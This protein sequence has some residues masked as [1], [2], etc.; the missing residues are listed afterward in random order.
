MTYGGGEDGEGNIFSIPMTGG[1]PTDLLDFNGTNGENPYGNL[2]LSGSTLY[3]MTYG[4]GY[5]GD[6]TLF[7]MNALGVGPLGTTGQTFTL[8]SSAVTVDTGVTVTSGDSDITGASMRI[9]N[10]QAGDSLNFYSQDGITGSYASGMLSLSGS[11]T[12]AQYAAALQ[13]VTFSTTSVVNETR[14]VDVVA[15]DTGD[16]GNVPSNTGVDSVVV[17][18]SRTDGDDVGP[19]RPCSRS[20]TR[21][22]HFPP[23][24]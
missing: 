23:A 22:A 16:T 7:S 11:A 10:Y 19:F 9:T 3:G 5:D 1:T 24:V 17:A 14:T 13:S 12:P 6:G 20:T 8:G 18:I 4:G 15:F 21:M 2:T